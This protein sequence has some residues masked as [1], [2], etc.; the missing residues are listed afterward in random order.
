MS[1]FIITWTKISN[2]VRILRLQVVVV[3]VL[4]TVVADLKQ[5]RPVDAATAR[6]RRILMDTDANMDDVFALF[7]VLKQNRSEFDLQAITISVNGWSDGGHAV[8]HLYD[9]LFMMDR[10]DVPVGVGGECG[11]TPNGSFTGPEVGGYLPL[12]DQGISTVGGCRYRQAIP[13]GSKG[14]LDVDTNLGLRKGFLPQVIHSGIPV[15]LIPLDATNTIPVSK[16]FLKALEQNQNTYEAQ[17]CFKSL[18][19]AHDTWY[20]DRFHET[21]FMWDYFMVGVAIS[22]MQNSNGNLGENEFSQMEYMNITVVTSNKPYGISDGS[23]PFFCS[24]AFTEFHLQKN[25]VHSGH[26]QTGML[27]PFCL[28]HN[29]KGRCEDGYTKEVTGPEAVQ[30]RVATKAKQ[31]SSVDGLLNITFYRS[32]LSVIN[33]P[34]QSGRFSIATQFPYYEEVMFRPDF[35]TRKLGRPVI[36]DMDMSPGDFLALFYLLK[37]PVEVIDLKGI[38]VTPT[39]WA[40]AATINIIYDVLHMMG[41]DDIPVGLGDAF[42][43][44][45][46]NPFFPAIGGCKYSQAI[47]YGSGGFLDSDT[48]YG[49]ARYLPRS[50]RRYTAENSVKFGAP[51]DTDHPELRQPLSLEVW[52]AIT[53]SMKP[54][55]KINI[56]TNGPLTTLAKIIQQN[57]SSMIQDV[58]IVGGHI[59]R[60]SKDKGNIFTVPGNKYGEFNMFLDP[61]A[62]KTVFNSELDIKLVPLDIQRRVSS[63]RKI[64]EKLQLTNKTPEAA[65]ASHLLSR[66]WHLQQ[67]HHRYHHMDMFLGEVIGAVVFAQN[68]SLLNQTFQSESLKLQASGEI[69]RVGQIGIDRRRGKSAKI[70]KSIDSVKYYEHFASVLGDHKQPTLIGSFDEQKRIWGRPHNDPV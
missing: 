2:M 29:G 33:S 3:V 49:F 34:E 28:V 15:T 53:E 64:L 55:Y 11:I 24:Q 68:H 69:S 52:R 18:K 63:F 19:L 17:Y 60:D 37:L 59:R 9:I 54:G 42:A 57:G 38:L 23:N 47:P 25:G 20:N 30:V 44:G 1:V 48:L 10:D 70:L 65:F 61:S 35:G 32:F 4:I 16:D 22:T 51:R 67:K 58:Y 26:V 31:D 6:P 56:L 14:R 66:L 12:I 5:R 13:V 50:P 7:Y 36:F 43:I 27:D 40:N 39:G 21:Y 45:E 46:T 8:D 62:T 41:R